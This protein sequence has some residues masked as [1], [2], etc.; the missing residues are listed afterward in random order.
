M[1]EY[2][3]MNKAKREENHMDV[4]TYLCNISFNEWERFWISFDV[5]RLFKDL[6]MLSNFLSPFVARPPYL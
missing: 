3:E 4:L 2:N 1:T 5:K 6:D